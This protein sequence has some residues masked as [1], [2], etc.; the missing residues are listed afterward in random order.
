LE[1]GHC[2][3]L[4]KGSLSKIDVV[5][6]ELHA[7]D[8]FGEISLLFNTKRYESA[9]SKDHCTIGAMNSE[10]FQEMIKLFP[11]IKNRLKLKSLE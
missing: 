7:G 5:V 6:N 10:A 8:I 9:R 4:V 11:E 2:E 3:T 1:S